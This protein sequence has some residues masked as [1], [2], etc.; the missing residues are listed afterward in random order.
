MDSYAKRLA[1]AMGG[2]KPATTKIKA[3]AADLDISYQAVV[4]V[5]DG[6]TDY[7]KVPNHYKAAAILRVNPE[8][9]ALGDG[10][11]RTPKSGYDDALPMQH[12][13]VE[14][15]VD[16]LAQIKNE[17]DRRIAC[18]VLMKVLDEELWRAPIGDMRPPATAPKLAPKMAQG[19]PPP[20][21]PDTPTAG[22]ATAPLGSGRAKPPKQRAVRS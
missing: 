14:E 4:K 18:S 10:D 8:W 16:A 9:L 20:A 21:A 6:K 15:V 5:L 22:P 7:L 17:N 3:L 11:M 12:P 2:G 13:A 1:L 19:T